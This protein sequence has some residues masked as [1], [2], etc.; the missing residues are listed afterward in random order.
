MCN[1][2]PLELVIH[3]RNAVTIIVK[4]FVVLNAVAII[5]L[6][7]VEDAVTIVV[8]ILCFLGVISHRNASGKI[9]VLPSFVRP[10]PSLSSS[11][12]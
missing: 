6:V 4:V 1:H 2:D 8:I 7:S 12:S 3:V 11:S 9:C 10:S 5:V